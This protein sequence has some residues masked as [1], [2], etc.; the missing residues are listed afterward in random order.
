M[1]TPFE[2]IKAWVGRSDDPFLHQA[3][4]AHLKVSRHI[5]FD[6]NVWTAI[7]PGLWHADAG[8]CV[9]SSLDAGVAFFAF[10]KLANAEDDSPGFEFSCYQGWVESLEEHRVADG[11]GV[12]SW[13]LAMDPDDC[14]VV[15]F[16]IDPQM[17]AECALAL[18][19]TVQWAADLG[20]QYRLRILTISF[21]DAPRAL[22]RLLYHYDLGA[23]HTMSLNPPDS[24]AAL[25]RE[26]HRLIQVNEDDLVQ[27]FQRESRGD[28]ERQGV[29]SWQKLPQFDHGQDRDVI[30]VPTMD[31]S[32]QDRSRS[33]NSLTITLEEDIEAA[34]SGFMNQY[35]AQSTAWVDGCYLRSVPPAFRSPFPL[36]N[37]DNL[38][39][40][41]N[42]HRQQ[43]IY[44]AVTG[45]PTW[46]NLPICHEERLEQVA[47]TVRTRNIPSRISIYTEASSIDDFISSGSLHRRLKVCNEHVGGFIAA[48]TRQFA[49]WGVD[50]SSVLCC[51]FESS[52]DKMAHLSL[53]D[54]LH[55]QGILGNKE[56]TIG[57]VG[58][59][60]D[61]FYK[62]LPVVGFDHRLA[63]FV[64]LPSSNAVVRQVKV[65]LAA[66]LTAGIRQLFTFDA[67]FWDKTLVLEC[68]GWSTN[69]APTGS[70][71]LALGLWR[72]GALDYD[73][74]SSRKVSQNTKDG[75]LGL[76]D[77]GISVDVAT[78]H[79]IS[80]AIT[81]ICSVFMA[82]EVPMLPV[83]A[84][85]ES[86][87]LKSEECI[88]LQKHLLQAYIF[89]LTRCVDGPDG[90]ILHDMT[91][92]MRIDLDHGIP[93]WIRFSINLKKSKRS[94]NANLGPIFGI[95]HGME[96]AENSG[97]VRLSD[98]TWIPIPVVAD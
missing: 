73:D 3:S 24:A 27:A 12:N 70:M 67:D 90:P 61:I 16:V 6:Q 54:R 39:L 49:R 78:C 71:W 97:T 15:A 42:S 50:T 22:R 38:H 28:L 51:F 63:L 77:C 93:Q 56:S 98:W 79:E 23:P 1:N 20:S 82:S 31:I 95:Y 35:R 10:Q 19:A 29:I 9:G 58:H 46:V 74:Y 45:Q 88:E 76:G 11:A 55:V 53:L 83:S 47:W 4:F 86:R 32:V 33:V 80:Q 7:F 89:Q 87:V 41:L 94:G 2:G 65:Q 64:A 25:R 81:A 96:R 36:E 5:L 34:F 62:V 14:I 60:L 72:R 18:I 66:I 59:H 26:V 44:D 84:S 8:Y 13:N 48:T 43:F 85:E 21:E 75:K 40:F 37:F 69:L 91:T 57:L 52:I 17:S 30:H 68:S 92:R